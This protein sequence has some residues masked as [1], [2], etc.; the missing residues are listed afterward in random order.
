MTMNKKQ[1]IKLQLLISLLIFFVIASTAIIDAS[2]SMYSYKKTLV[3]THLENN[4]N[5]VKKLAG[6]TEHQ[7]NYMQQNIVA[8]GEFAGSHTF[9]QN[10]L[11]RWYKANKNYF[12][13][14]FMTDD[15]G[16][17]KIISPE[18]IEF[19]DHT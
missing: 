4:Y 18:I 1:G 11:D 6:T 5:Y 13:S 15:E 8:I 3:E 16:T 17:I 7:L 12:N 14:I 10:N 9:S 19:K 2:I